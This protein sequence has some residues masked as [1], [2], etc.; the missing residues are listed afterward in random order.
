M[1]MSI[2]K[3]VNVKTGYAAVLLLFFLLSYILPLGARDLVVP[4]ETRYAEIPREMIAEK[5]WVVPHLNGL[6]YFEKPALG[7]W[8]HAASLLVFGENNFAVRLPSAV[9]VGLSA[10]LIFLLVKHA[11]RRREKEDD[12]FAPF[13]AA[14]IFLSSFEV[15]GVGNTAVLD[16]LFS[17]FLTMSIAAF[18]FASEEEPGSKR[19]KGFLI[20]AGL[21]CG[22]AFLTKGF[23]AFA[24]PALVLMPYLIWQRRYRNL[25]RMTWLPILVAVLTA[26]PWSIA[27]HLREPDFWR[28]F[29]WNEHIR[30]F[31]A[32]SAQHKESFWFFFLTAPGMFI[33]WTFVVPAALP[34]IKARL[35]EQGEEGRLLKLSICWL[36][37]PFLF[38][39]LSNGKLLTYILPCFPPFAILIAIG[40]MHALRKNASNRAFQWGTLVGG[41]LFGLILIAFLYVQFFG[42]NGFHPYERQWK[43]VMVVNGLVFFLL[44]FFWALKS[45]T[46]KN[47]VLLYGMAPLLLFLVAHFAIPEQ[48]IEVKSPGV[49]LKQYQQAIAADD[50]VISDENSL[51]AVC[52]YLRRSNVYLLEGAGE[53]DYGLTYKDANVRVLDIPSVAALIKQ[54]RGKTVLIA[55]VRDISRWR[56]QLPPPLFQDQNGTSGYALWRL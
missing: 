18:Y 36:A 54:N 45:P 13:L 23:L 3:L 9:A 35:A 39:S 29:F 33:P 11:Y 4:D 56:D 1:K 50:I 44:F 12:D 30:R 14:L 16:G 10:L 25:L 52:W 43:V 15:F 19:E 49:L 37:L 47:K 41:A 24:L 6:R 51:R 7:Y 2:H 53:L 40:L 27:V 31:I 22:L 42:F 5:D 8:V 46:A 21:S 48:T 55:R 38:F 17:L 28:F 26:L 20:L 34:G 32:D